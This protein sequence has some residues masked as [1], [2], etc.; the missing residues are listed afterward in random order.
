M[1]DPSG[2]ANAAHRRPKTH[3]AA[4]LCLLAAL[5]GGIALQ[6]P[7]VALLGGLLIRLGL[8]VNPVRRG[9]RLGAISLQTAVVLLGLT[10][11]FD[12][13][14]SVSA[15]YGVT[16]AA[17][18]LTTLLLGWAFARLIRSDR[19][20]TSL[21]TSGTAIC[22]A[23]AIATLAPVVGA[24]PHQLAAATGIVF[25]L[26]AVALFTFPTIGAWLELSQETFGAWVALAIH[27][28]SS[29]VATAAIY[30]DEAAAVA[31]TVKLGRALWLI[32]LA[33][34]AS[35]LF[36]KREA[37]LRVP[38]FILLFV[39]AAAVGGA[40]EIS[41]Q[42]TQGIGFVS[43]TLLVIALGLIGLELDR[44]SLGKLS[45]SSLVLGIGLWLAVVPLALV[46]VLFR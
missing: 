23:T 4:W 14:V 15:D 8:D 45:L 18:V 36:A 44:A 11:G 33:F 37:K 21:L 22:G 7:A 40:A 38:P 12:R 28:T 29:V 5:G 2:Y 3:L 42:V 46:L 34:A 32:P 17:Y 25:L 10:L 27:D 41:E 31:T 24:R 1:P 16:V 9:M 39:A 43:K 13:M 30:G 20:E 6:N 35:L 19:V 26:N